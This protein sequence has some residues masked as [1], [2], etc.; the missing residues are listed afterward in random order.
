[1]RTSEMLTM[2]KPTIPPCPPRLST[3][4]IHSLKFLALNAVA[5]ELDVVS[6]GAAAVIVGEFISRVGEGRSVG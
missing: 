6:A 4:L 2:T 5:A 1:M 3:C